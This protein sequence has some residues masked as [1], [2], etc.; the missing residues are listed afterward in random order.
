MT[1]NGEAMPLPETMYGILEVRGEYA[2]GMASSLGVHA[3]G[4][5]VV[6]AAAGPATLD[7]VVGDALSVLDFA[8]APGALAPLPLQTVVGARL[9]GPVGRAVGPHE[10]AHDLGDVLLHDVDR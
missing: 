10:D 8:R 5:A 2:S 4:S 7:D 9:D 3:D 1:P 6:G